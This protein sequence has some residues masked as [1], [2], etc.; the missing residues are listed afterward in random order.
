MLRSLKIVRT[1][2]HHQLS[3]SILQKPYTTSNP[4]Q[5]NCLSQH[6]AHKFCKLL[7]NCLWLTAKKKGERRRR[8]LPYDYLSPAAS[9][10]WLMENLFWTFLIDKTCMIHNAWCMLHDPMI[11]M[12]CCILYGILCMCIYFQPHTYQLSYIFRLFVLKKLTLY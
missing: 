4:S 2:C 1:I 3:P 10:G 5:T 8:W 11:H 6:Y 7:T 12:V 9:M